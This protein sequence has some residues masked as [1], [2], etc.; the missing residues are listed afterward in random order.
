M[1]EAVQHSFDWDK[2][3]L[4]TSMPLLFQAFIISFMFDFGQY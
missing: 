1:I 2:L 3:A 4:F